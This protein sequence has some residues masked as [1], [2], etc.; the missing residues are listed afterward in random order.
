MENVDEESIFITVATGEPLKIALNTKTQ[1][2]SV[3]LNDY[4]TED[5]KSL[6]NK[7]PFMYYSIPSVRD[8]YILL[9]D[10]IRKL[11]DSSK[12]SIPQPDVV[13]R[14]SCI[15]FEYHDS[16]IMKDMIFAKSGN[17][18]KKF[19]TKNSDDGVGAEDDDDDYDDDD[20]DDDDLFDVVELI[21]KKTGDNGSI[22]D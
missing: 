10:G 17:D 16:L 18:D 11:N 8:T 20:D 3:D 2:D 19:H 5:F 6:K 7:D 22:N 15:T 4:S 1:V 9:G 14:K 13:S 12:T 21:R